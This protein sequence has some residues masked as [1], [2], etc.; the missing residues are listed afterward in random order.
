V[1]SA[2]S[3]QV[4]AAF[5]ATVFPL[6]GPFG[7]AA[8]RQLVSAIALLAIARPPLRRIGLKRLTPALLL[9]VVLVGMNTALYAAVERIGL[10]L[11]VTIEFLGPLAVALASGGRGWRGPRRR[12]AVCGALAL[13]GV[14]ALTGPFDGR[15]T[16]GLGLL[17][18][19]A[20]AVLWAA[21]ILLNQRAGSLPGVT[22]TAVAGLT[23][24]VL[25][26]PAL[27]VLLARLSPAQLPHVL[28]IGA[29]TGVLSSA[30]PYSLDL[31]ILRTLPRS[32][33]GMLQSVHPVAAAVFGLLV[34]GQHLAAPQMLGIAAVCTANVLAVVAHRSR[35]RAVPG[36][37]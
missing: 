13:A 26:L 20:A 17:L 21:Y 28:L 36:S 6:V 27:V 34:L 10:G 11:A 1:V 37:P 25:T 14:V 18:G 35:A 30:L 2:S 8:M 33:F 24:T 5:G 7:V 15:A 4:G 3:V 16:D 9:G 12:D 32:L 22:G 23:G 29:V 31:V 19:V